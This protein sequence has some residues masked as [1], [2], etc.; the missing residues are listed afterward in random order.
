MGVNTRILANNG[1]LGRKKAIFVF[2]RVS[3]S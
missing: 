3:A 2:I 1:P